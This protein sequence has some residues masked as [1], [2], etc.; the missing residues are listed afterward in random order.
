VKP[1]D[2]F[3]LCSNQSLTH[4]IKYFSPFSH[5]SELP[6]S[7]LQK[8]EK[9][10]KDQKEL[11]LQIN[12]CFNH[13][14]ALSE[15]WPL[16]CAFWTCTPG[17]NKRTNKRQNT[18]WLHLLGKVTHHQVTSVSSFPS[19]NCRH[20]NTATTHHLLFLRGKGA[21][22]NGD[23]EGRGSASL[24]CDEKSEGCQIGRGVFF[25]ILTKSS[26]DVEKTGIRK[27]IANKRK[28]GFIER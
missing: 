13:K 2:F 18:N 8:A 23:K 5:F 16:P 3:K 11:K 24:L 22:H 27:M 9:G 7:T 26:G 21:G 12:T 6:P 10:K 1:F 17:T 25:R 19:F 20:H 14:N 4:K 15:K 28:E